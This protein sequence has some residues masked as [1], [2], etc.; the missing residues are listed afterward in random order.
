MPR[1]KW[2]AMMPRLPRAAI[3]DVSDVD[4]YGGSAFINDFNSHPGEYV[5][6]CSIFRRAG[7]FVCFR[8][9]R[10]AFD[11]TERGVKTRTTDDC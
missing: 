1:V 9:L 10:L 8:S 11:R 3:L 5:I 6:G 7:L 2:N 4:L